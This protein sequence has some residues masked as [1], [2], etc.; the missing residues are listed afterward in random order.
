MAT[1]VHGRSVTVTAPVRIADVGGWSDTWFATRG[2][3]CHL[4]VGPGVTVEASER[5]EPASALPVRLVCPDLDEDHRCGPSPTAGWRA[6]LP[7]RRPLVEHAVGSVCERFPPRMSTTV[8]IRSAVPPGASLGT[9]ASVVVGVITALE[10]LLGP[11][12][13]PGLPVHLGDTDRHRIAR[14][15]HEVETDRA[16]REAGVQDQWAA[17][18]GGAQLL[19]IP[20]YPMVRR[21]PI[22]ISD[23][24]RTTLR[25]NVVTVVIGPHD[26][27][28]VHE[29]VVATMTEDR[30]RSSRVVLA[31]LARLAS[32][33]AAALADED[34]A[35]WA[36]T[37]IAATA[38]QERLH[39]GLVGS[40]HHR[41]IDHGRDH[42]ALGW[43]VNGAGG[44]GGS[45]TLVFA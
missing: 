32:K 14:D 39:P 27:S 41:L 16:G 43:K 25:D 45:I 23:D 29:H 19:E 10:A 38:Y 8:T 44:A 42:D 28:A 34:L 2:A 40:A 5:D 24:F 7:G 15:S 9:S 3:V 33:A 21:H 1:D 31:D 35:G 20:R 37:L 18:F 26:S 17:A 13:A 36:R 12:G 22:V 30:D 4:G 6:P 11:E